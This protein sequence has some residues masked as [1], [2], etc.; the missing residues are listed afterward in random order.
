MVSPVLVDLRNVYRT[1]DMLAKGFVYA[2]IG[3]CATVAAKSPPKE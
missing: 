1:D 3:A 2:S